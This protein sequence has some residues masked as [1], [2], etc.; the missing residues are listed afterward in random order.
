M[1]ASMKFK[2][3]SPSSGDPTIHY[4]TKRIIDNNNHRKPL[5]QAE[6]EQLTNELMD[7]EN[8]FDEEN[9]CYSDY[10]RDSD[11]EDNFT[12]SSGPSTAG[13]SG[14]RNSKKVAQESISHDKTVL[15]SEVEVDS[16]FDDSDVDLTERS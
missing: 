9:F 3:S 12:L 4:L 10:G 6:L 2:V 16:T 5:T 7:D 13:I 11:A 14:T 15:E 8:S 1:P